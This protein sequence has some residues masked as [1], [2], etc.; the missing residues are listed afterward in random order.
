MVLTPQAGGANVEEK[1]VTWHMRRTYPAGY[2]PGIREHVGRNLEKGKQDT[3]VVNHA[4]LRCVCGHAILCEVQSAG[5][6]IGYLTFVDDEP[7]SET[8]G[9]RIKECP[10]CG[11]QL[12]L[13]MLYR[14]NR[15]G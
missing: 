6:R 7:T 9:R 11:E 8:R 12:G 13:P 4:K 2:A 1:G 15:S 10:N 5:E 14:I 3:G